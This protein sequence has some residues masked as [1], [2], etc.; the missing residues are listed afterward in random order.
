MVTI[1]ICFVGL[2]VFLGCENKDDLTNKKTLIGQWVATNNHAGDNRII[3][4]T[5]NLFVEQYFDYIFT[6]QIIP[7]LYLSPYVTY[8]LSENKITFTIHYFYPSAA[9]F[10]ETFD[11]VLRGNSLAIKGFSNPF[12]LTQEART[13]VHFTRVE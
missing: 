1:V 9:N 7:A 12:S 5:E 2:T 3:F 6:N 4:F 8:S 10:S 11:Y 13:D